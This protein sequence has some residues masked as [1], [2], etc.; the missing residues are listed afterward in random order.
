MDTSNLVSL[1]EQLDD[2]IDDIEDVLEP[3]LKQSLSLTAQNLPLM[4][5]AKLHVLIAYAIESLIF[6]FLRINGTDAKAHPV[7][8]E[9]TRVKGYFDK[10]K[11]IETPPEKQNMTLDKKAAARFIKHGLAGNDK[12]DLERA[13][14]QAKERAMAQLKAV[15]MARKKQVPASEAVPVEEQE[16]SSSED[17]AEYIHAPVARGGKEEEEHISES[18]SESGDV[19]SPPAKMEVDKN[20][21]EKSGTQSDKEKEQKKLES[22]QKR[23]K[24]EDKMRRREK[25]KIKKMKKVKRKA[26]K[27]EKA[28]QSKLGLEA[29][30]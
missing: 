13:E 14:K 3:L 1:L 22:E 6:S 21:I 4:E 19:A 26:K 20:E 15:Q 7:F 10:I 24:Q 18:N 2:D 16:E 30:G 23:L 29:N 25:R 11:K 17:E 8:T 9:L 5:K 28:K 27:A 12:Y